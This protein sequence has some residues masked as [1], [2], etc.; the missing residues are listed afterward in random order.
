MALVLPKTLTAGQPENV[1]DLNSNLNYLAT[2][3]DTINAATPYFRAY[4]SADVSYA[5]GATVIFNTETDPNGWYDNAT[6]VFLP[7][8]AGMYRV[9][10]GLGLAES[11]TANKWLWASLL[12]GGGAARASSAYAFQVDTGVPLNT[13]GTT[14][15]AMNGTTDSLHVS[16]AHNKGSAASVV[17]SSSL[18]YFEANRVGV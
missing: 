5:T 4:R 18:S 8:T 9:S 13:V 16:V 17:G 3:I 11:F 7:T 1:N 14:L 2:Q 6:G 12:T 15:V 10:W